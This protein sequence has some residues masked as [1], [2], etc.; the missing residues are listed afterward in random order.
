MPEPVEHAPPCSG[1]PCTCGASWGPP[2]DHNDWRN[3]DWRTTDWV[4]PYGI[5]DGH[6]IGHHVFVPRGWESDEQC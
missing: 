6:Y 1:R 4:L 3:P 2:K 5:P